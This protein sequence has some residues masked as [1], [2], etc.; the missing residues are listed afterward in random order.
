MKPTN[1]DGCGACC[2][3]LIFK[4]RA[5]NRVDGQLLEWRGCRFAGEDMAIP[6]PC[7]HLDLET[8]KCKI[9][10][11]RPQACKDFEIGC[12]TCLGVRKLAGL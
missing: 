1:C 12:N 3:F 5:V 11:D 10:E 8:K 4:M 9:Y 2:S 7:K 6:L